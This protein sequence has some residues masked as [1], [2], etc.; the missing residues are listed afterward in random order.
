MSEKWLEIE[1]FEGYY[2]VSSLGN[3]RSIDRLVKKRGHLVPQY[4]KYITKTLNYNGYYKV[5]LCKEGKK[6]T[7]RLHRLVALAF[8]K[9][10]KEKPQVNH[11]NGIKTDNRVVNLEWV[12]ASENLYHAVKH[13]LK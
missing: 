3:I 8:I 12:T 2:E 11:K 9:N 4:S 10:P 7:K 13:G 1:G 6:F 5:T